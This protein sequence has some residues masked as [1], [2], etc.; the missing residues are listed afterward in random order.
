MDEPRW[1]TVVLYSLPLPLPSPGFSAQ[2]GK[3]EEPGSHGEL[4]KQHTEKE[5][6][7]KEVASSGLQFY[8]VYNRTF[9]PNAKETPKLH[10]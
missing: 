8:Q 6:R 3:S 10:G 1:I 4:R 2:P 5:P 9:G 7:A